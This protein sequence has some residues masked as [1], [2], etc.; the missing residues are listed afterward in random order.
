MDRLRLLNFAFVVALPAVFASLCGAQASQTP[1]TVPYP[2]K[3]VPSDSLPL[4]YPVKPVP[5]VKSLSPFSDNS[6]PSALEHFI[7]YRP[8]GQMN[9]ADHD[10]A[11]KTQ[12][13][14]RD[15]AQFA[16]IE[17]DKDKWSY[18]QLECQAIP[19]HL[20]LLFQG[21]SGAGDVSL[22]SASIPRAGKGH[23]RIIPVERRGFT[24]FSPAP[25]S[26]IAM[27]IFNRI[28]AEEPKGPPADWLATSLCYAALTDPRLEIT[29]SPHQAPDSDLALSF[30]PSLEVEPGG[31]STVRFV[32]AATPR[33]PMQ[34]ALTFDPKNQLV[35]V[36]HFPAPVYATRIIP[37]N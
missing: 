24:L 32:D 21:D 20:F 13:A 35:K 23:V 14:I 18:R 12:P 28:R 31:A 9:G 7:L 25:V 29:L 22:F 37:K 34:W 5:G 30:P 26:E 16:G 6:S 10:L 36:E 11:Q 19:D 27:A 1:R 8:E 4:P 33:Q 15:A 17:F 2:V 3:P